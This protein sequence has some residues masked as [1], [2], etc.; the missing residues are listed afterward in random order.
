MGSEAYTESMNEWPAGG[1]PLEWNHAVRKFPCPEHTG[2]EYQAQD[3]RSKG[4]CRLEAIML[5]PIGE[6][7][8][9]QNG[10][11]GMAT[12]AALL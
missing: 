9:A 7:Q 2:E 5:A 10:V 8:K 6:P 3:P 1:R 12:S 11:S 4:P